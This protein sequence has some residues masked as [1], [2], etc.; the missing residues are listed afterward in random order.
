MGT[1]RI[2]SKFDKDVVLLADDEP[3]HLDWLIDYLSAKGLQTIVATTVKD[4]IE[5]VEKGA[6]RAYLIDLNIPLGGWIPT[7]T[8]GSQTYDDYHGLYVLKLVRSQG[9][10]G[11]RVI[12]YSAHQNEP[13][14]ASIRRLYCGYI[15]KGKPREL[16]DEI[17]NLLKRPPKSP[18][19]ARKPK[20][21]LPKARQ[22][23]VVRKKRFTSGP[24]LKKRQR[25]IAK[26]R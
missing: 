8:V 12:A 18:F 10:P 21:V 7:V 25:G 13:I 22:R 26:R 5:Q 9:N 17:E 11:N 6:Y 24:K 19:R 2:P 23:Q 16:K 3:E 1:V 15:V 14:I 20:K 4:A